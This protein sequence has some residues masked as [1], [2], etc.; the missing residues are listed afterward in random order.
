MTGTNSWQ[1]DAATLLVGVISRVWGCQHKAKLALKRTLQTNQGWGI[2]A[3]VN[4]ESK[5]SDK[6]T[7]ASYIEDIGE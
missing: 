6:A 2:K 3:I 5:G 1:V 4:M 7:T